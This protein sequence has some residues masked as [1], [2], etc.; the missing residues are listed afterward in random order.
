MKKLLPAILSLQLLS[1]SF[2]AAQNGAGTQ[3]TR[4]QPNAPTAAAASGATRYEADTAHSNVGFIVPILGGLSKVRGKFNEFTA[5]INYDEK[6]IENSSV[7]ATIK[8]ASID[9]GIERRDGH[10]RTPDFST[11]RSFPK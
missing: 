1:F 8:T 9:T 3:T 10:L 11:P 6:K 5:Q 2:V 7:T 4:Q